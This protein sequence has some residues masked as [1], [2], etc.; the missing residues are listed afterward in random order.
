M[1][2]KIPFFPNF[3]DEAA[4]EGYSILVTRF[5]HIERITEAVHRA[6]QND[7][8]MREGRLEEI[9]RLNDQKAEISRQIGI[10]QRDRDYGAR[11]SKADEKKVERWQAQAVGISQTVKELHAVKSEPIFPVDKLSTFFAGVRN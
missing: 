7:R 2:M 10:A 4:E 11:I 6:A 5:P 9:R 1:P 8:A 3:D